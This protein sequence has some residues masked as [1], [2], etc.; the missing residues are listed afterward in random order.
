MT[1]T[2]EALSRG[3]A[4]EEEEEDS[5]SDRPL[6]LS[7]LVGASDGFFDDS[8]M[9][10]E[11]AP[12]M[13]APGS[14]QGWMWSSGA[15]SAAGASQPTSSSCSATGNTVLLETYPHSAGAS[16]AAAASVSDV[17][18]LRALY[19]DAGC[20]E[21]PSCVEGPPSS[22]GV[23][24]LPRLLGPVT[25]SR[26]SPARAAASTVPIPP[27][28]HKLS[29]PPLPSSTD[30]TSAG[31]GASSSYLSYLQ[32]QLQE[33]RAVSQRLAQQQ[34]LL[35]LQIMAALPR[36]AY[37]ASAAGVESGGVGGFGGHA[38]GGFS[39][40]PIPSALLHS[41]AV[42]SVYGSS[43]GSTLEYD[44]Y[45][46]QHSYMQPQSYMQQQSLSEQQEQHHYLLQHLQQQQQAGQ[47]RHQQLQHQ[48]L[49]HQQLQHQQLQAKLLSSDGNPSTAAAAVEAASKGATSSSIASEQPHSSNIQLL[50]GTAPPAPPPSL[51]SAQCLA[52]V[53]SRPR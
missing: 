31:A 50:P 28:G 48:Q 43:A 20:S 10:A 33:Q 22:G 14:R 47:H 15:V 45:M 51:V 8:S 29:R 1:G 13:S 36:T 11:A 24:P 27:G 37:A 6:M 19:A 53:P 41:P 26:D 34:R 35:Q 46:Q 4:A 30:A 49:Q 23:A 38:V 21:G 52:P 18:A 2:R 32:A 5:D 25:G 44:G 16:A 9:P 39:P 40:W 42:G 3:A 7:L 17:A 12:A